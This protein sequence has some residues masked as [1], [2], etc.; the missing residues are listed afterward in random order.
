MKNKIAAFL[1]ISACLIFTAI[2]M[3][4]PKPPVRTP[5]LPKTFCGLL[6]EQKIEVPS[7]YFGTVPDYEEINISAADR[8]IVKEDC[9]SKL[10]SLEVHTNIKS[11][12]PTGPFG[13][14]PFDIVVTYR[15]SKVDLKL[16]DRL[17]NIS[18]D[19]NIVLIDKNFDT[20]VYETVK[21]EI[22]HTKRITI[23]T[24]EGKANR[25]VECTV[26][27]TGKNLGC[28]LFYYYEGYDINISGDYDSLIDFE[29]MRI[30]VKSF[31]DKILLKGAL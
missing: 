14:S 8:L 1:G 30:F 19:K 26:N 28:E 10:N 31:L 11:G 3:H 5:F 23:K 24:N 17:K 16:S 27:S 20:S 25:I 13:Q 18:T 12:L 29:N 2:H 15:P 21:D 22:N 9:S 6:G 4:N 7:E